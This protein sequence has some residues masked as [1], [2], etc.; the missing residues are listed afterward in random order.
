MEHRP[1]TRTQAGPTDAERRMTP[2]LRDILQAGGIDADLSVPTQDGDVTVWITTRNARTTTG[3]LP[4]RGR[5]TPSVQAGA[6]T[7]RGEEG[8]T[9]AGPVASASTSR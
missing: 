6:S 5:T 4:V 7:G 3:C 8:R 1:T 9:V 2:V